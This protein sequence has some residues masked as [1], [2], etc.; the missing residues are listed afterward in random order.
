MRERERKEGR[1]TVGAGVSIG[2]GEVIILQTIEERLAVLSKAL[3]EPKPLE[4]DL[5]LFSCDI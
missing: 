3:E 2:V 5:P 1:E 4:Y